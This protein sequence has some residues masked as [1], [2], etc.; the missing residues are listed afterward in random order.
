M[1]DVAR[2]D[3]A[4]VPAEVDQ[5]RERRLTLL[6]SAI[7]AVA[8]IPFWW[9]GFGGHPDEWTR[10]RAPGIRLLGPDRADYFAVKDGRR[11]QRRPVVCWAH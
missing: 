6:L 11:G 2:F 9:R 8:R 3:D 10:R 5:R 7:A 1:T 4:S